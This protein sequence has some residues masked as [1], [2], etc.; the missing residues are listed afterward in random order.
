MR[1]S[2]SGLANRARDLIFGTQ[3]EVKEQSVLTKCHVTRMTFDLKN[4]V[5]L[6][7]AKI[8]P[9]AVSGTPELHT[10]MF[11]NVLN[12]AKVKGQ[13]A[14]PKFRCSMWSPKRSLFKTR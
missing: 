13:G 14:S 1:I 3:G 12:D 2:N 7:I 8:R 9:L 4:F 10:C 11:N 6:L 5:C